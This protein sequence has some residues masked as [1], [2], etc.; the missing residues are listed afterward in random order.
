MNLTEDHYSINPLYHRISRYKIRTALQSEN[1]YLEIFH[2]KSNA[3]SRTK[4]PTRNC[5]FD[6]P[7]FGRFLYGAKFLQHENIPSLMSSNTIYIDVQT[8]T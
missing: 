7:W 1:H 5:G 8:S 4:Y 3:L 2:H 6:T